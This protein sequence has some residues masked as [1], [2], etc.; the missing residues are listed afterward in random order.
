ML[1]I[2]PR[3]APQ[4]VPKRIEGLRTLRAV[5]VSAGDF[6]SLVLVARP[7][8][9]GAVFS[10]GSNTTGRLG[11]GD[12]EMRSKPEEIEV[13]RGS[14]VRAI[15]AGVNYSLVA[16]RDK[17]YG[18]GV[19]RAFAPAG[20]I[21][22]AGSAGTAAPVPLEMRFDQPRLRVSIIVEPQH[23]LPPRLTEQALTN[24]E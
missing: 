21:P 24:F 17:V 16:T 13:L 22:D 8:G 11:H 20:H 9:G 18:F 6:H 7:C 19:V 1:A 2:A 4:L 14:S 3:Q 23:D 15:C 10:F 5:A 12:E